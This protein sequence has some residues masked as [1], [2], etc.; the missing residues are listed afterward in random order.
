MRCARGDGG[1]PGCGAII[2]SSHDAV[3]NPA[4]G[5]VAPL[6]DA[7]LTRMIGFDPTNRF[8]RRD[9]R[10]AFERLHEDGVIDLQTEGS[11]LFRIFGPKRRR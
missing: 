3:P 11:G 5:F 10:K 7:D 2:R 4:A 1:A 9:A 6:T 8:R